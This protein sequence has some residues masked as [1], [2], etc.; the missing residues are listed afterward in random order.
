MANFAFG[1][2]AASHLI[3]VR[4]LDNAASA[5]IMDRLGMQYRGIE[6]WYGE[7]LAT[8]VLSREDWLQR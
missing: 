3:A 5:R 2:L 4:H 1:G 6:T 8:H 7:L